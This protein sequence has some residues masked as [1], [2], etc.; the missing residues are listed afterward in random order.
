MKKDN[1]NWWT[2]PKNKKEVER[3]SWWNHPE[4]KE[5]F[6]LPISV[7]ES[8]GVW[9]ATCNDETDKFLG[10][11]LHGG[12]QGK[13]KEE[14]IDKMFHII[15]ITHDFSEE[16]KLNYQRFVPFRKGDWK[17]IG[18]KWFN[19]FGIGFYFRVGKNMKHG[20][21]IPFTNVNVRISSDWKSY[22]IYKGNTKE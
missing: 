20:K 1:Y 15:R 13:T 5:M 19:I 11:K 9:V 2:D 18:G 12:A 21:Y 17:M 3:L 8:D 6:Q 4:N 14:A 16:E 10:E 22:R 7:I